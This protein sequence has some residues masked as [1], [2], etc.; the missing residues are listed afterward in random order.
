[1]MNPIRPSRP[2]SHASR[3]TE[4]RRPCGPIRVARLAL[5]AI[6]LAVGFLLAP[7]TDLTAQS[8]SGGPIRLTEPLTLKTPGQALRPDEIER[9]AF[10]LKFDPAA[11]PLEAGQ[12]ILLPTPLGDAQLEVTRATSWVP[13]TYSVQARGEDGAQA[14]LTFANGRLTGVL[15]GAERMLVHFRHDPAA[16]LSYA[17]TIRHEALDHLRCADD[18]RVTVPAAPGIGMRLD[19]RSART[20]SP[21]STGRA[22]TGGDEGLGA[23]PI[24]IPTVSAMA[25]MTAHTITVDVLIVYTPAAKTWAET[26]AIGS[27]CTGAGT[28]DAY[29]AAAMSLAQT[30][31]DNGNLPMTFRL[32]GLSQIAYD[33][34]ADGVDSGTRLERL[35]ASP[36]FN[37]W[38]GAASMDEVH[39]LRSTTGADLVAGLFDIDDT[40]GLAWRIGNPAG[41]PELGFSVN[42]VQQVATTTTVA[43]EMGHNMGLDHSRSQ[44]SNAAGVFGGVFPYSAGYRW[45]A[46]GA[47]Y[48]T[49]MG[50]G[51]G[52]HTEIPIFSTPLVNWNGSPAGTLTDGGSGPADAVTS[53][54]Q[55]KYAVS[56][57]QTTRVDPPSAS[58]PTDAVQ[59]VL[60]D[61]DTDYSLTLPIANSGTSDLMWHAEVARGNALAK[62]V[63]GGSPATTEWRL[64]DLEPIDRQADSGSASSRAASPPLIPAPVTQ[65]AGTVSTLLDDGFETVSTGSMAVSN[66]W[67]ANAEATPFTIS[68][69][70]PATGAQ[71][72][73]LSS[74]G[75]SS[76]L[77]PYLGPQASGSFEVSFDLHVQS[78][79]TPERFDLYITDGTTG[80][81]SAGLVLANGFIYL[82]NDQGSFSS[83]GTN[84]VTSAYRTFRIVYDPVA[85]A[86]SYHYGGSLIANMPYTFG[87]A[88]DYLEFYLSGAPS[89]TVYD[90]DNVRVTRD[91]V[92]PWFDLAAYAGTVPAGQT[93]QIRLDF[94][95]NGLTA[96]TYTSTLQVNTNDPANPTY[97]VPL[98]FTIDTAPVTQSATFTTP[99]PRLLTAPFDGAYLADL[100]APLW[101]QGAVGSDAPSAA[102]NVFLYDGTGWVSVT[103]LT[104]QTLSAGQGFAVWVYEDTNY[105]GAPDLPATI[106]FTGKPNENR[107]VLGA[108]FAA[109]QGPGDAGSGWNLFGN[110]YASALTA[111]SIGLGDPS[112]GN[113]DFGSTLYVYDPVEQAWKSWNRAAATG[114]LQDGRIAPFQGFFV[115]STRADAQLAFEPGMRTDLSSRLYRSSSGSSYG[116]YAPSPSV[117]LRVATTDGALRD[118]A[119]L[120]FAAEGLEGAGAED[121]VKLLPLE[122]A[123]RVAVWLQE[124]ERPAE[125]DDGDDDSGDDGG[126]VNGDDAR[127]RPLEIGLLPIE[128]TGQKRIPLHLARMRPQL[129]EQGVPTWLASIE[130]DS[131]LLAWEPVNLAG[132]DA[133]IELHDRATGERFD[134]TRQGSRHVATQ[135][136][137]TLDLAGAHLHPVLPDTRFELLVDYA[138]VTTST[139]PGGGLDGD[140]PAAYRL[141]QNVPNPFNP[142]TRI[143]FTLARPQPVRLEVFSAIGERVAVLRQGVHPAGTHSVSFDGARLSSGVYLYRLTTPEFSRTRS[144]LLMK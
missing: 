106:S 68:A 74:T 121:G 49:V 123:D 12:R 125:G 17:A 139:E 143:E 5:L 73:R 128:S 96:G 111:Q 71:H 85:N 22:K 103:N 63:A 35:T 115:Q 62:P 61:T 23:G 70:N 14:T 89:G 97:T 131:L 102:P 45:A 76:V 92:T 18:E 2:H 41:V 81:L 134:L 65:V 15:H 30:S 27:G 93:G 42:R 80:D 21:G 40:G 72:L 78:P 46:G 53:L 101:I 44:T 55:I 39:T 58:V 120:A 108:T 104:T 129:D 37:P 38:G 67:R 26:C 135:A 24:S 126:D 20:H 132:L 9:A 124:A 137:G 66:G 114:T 87:D 59:V 77:S 79:G 98:Q 100:L 6:T 142:T 8:V 43:H 52:T 32:V 16:G 60:R 10:H 133:T 69:A 127:Q 54:N 88:P 94:N 36:S 136:G 50:Y 47:A 141:S 56:T 90:I 144:M 117:R 130:P 7:P 11:T 112:G 13:G 64:P 86:V 116:Q 19:A 119:I 91:G 109:D 140:R 75:S 83:D 84:L 57:Y 29:A 105:D 4:L 107:I 31:V 51:E 1:M 3:R 33:E 118:E 82:L 99:G 122:A 28:I 95:S 138:G 34:T 48:S 110:P 113:P 25:A